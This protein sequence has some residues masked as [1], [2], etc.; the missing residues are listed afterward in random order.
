[1]LPEF[2]HK[3]ISNLLTKRQYATLRILV[4]MLQ[5]YRT[6][7][8][9]KLAAILPIPI[10]YQS[11]RRHIQRFLSL[12]QLTT[13]L[14]DKRSKEKFKSSVN[15][16]SKKL[17]KAGGSQHPEI[18]YH[19]QFQNAVKKRSSAVDRFPGIKQ[20][21]QDNSR[22]YNALNQWMSQPTDWLHLCHLK[23]C[24]WMIIALIHTGNV[25]L[26]KW[27]MYIPCRGKF[28]QSRQRRIQRWLNNPR[29]NVTLNS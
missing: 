4:L 24:V 7:Q 17:T 25:N 2:Y 16:R 9:E 21:L 23:T 27:S 10:K 28:A 8:I 6:I 15:K 22:L 18:R 19:S 20:L 11:R 14:T 1:M 13:W 29:I 3:C 26:T 12:P 5:S